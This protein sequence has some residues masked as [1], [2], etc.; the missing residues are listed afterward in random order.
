M[1]R[2]THHTFKTTIVRDLPDDDASEELSVTVHY[3]IEPGYPGTRLDPPEPARVEIE[4]IVGADG[5]VV[6]TTAKEDEAIIEDLATNR[7]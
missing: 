3:T 1:S 7:Y 4:K 5:K 2:A 6:E